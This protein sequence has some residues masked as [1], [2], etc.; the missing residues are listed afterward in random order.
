MIR[1]NNLIYQ[2]VMGD[3]VPTFYDACIHSVQNY[4][5]DYDIHHVIQ[6]KPKLKIRPLNSQRSER[7]VERLGYLPIYEK[8]NAFELFDDYDN[9]CILDAD[10]YITEHA[11]NIFEHIGDDV[12]F[13]GVKEK[14]LPI[15]NQYL[16]KIK[17]YSLGQYSGFRD[18]NQ[19]IDSKYGIEFYNMGLML[20]SNKL[21]KHLKGDTPEQFIRRP[22]FERF[23]NGE[24]Q[25]RWSTDQTLLNYWIKKE[26]IVTQDLSWKWNALFKAV[27]DDKLHE[28]YFIHFFLSNNLPQKGLE[29]PEIIQNLSSASKI[30]YGHK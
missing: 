21:K 13:A 30:K 16:Q 15:T 28:A 24:G 11:P 26:N 7:A 27:Q 14:D 3:I 6:R 12:E 9:I 17:N 5:S 22:E 29:I 4:C 2:V 18:I 1:K 8:E 20:M 23:V 10:I 25:W 19:T